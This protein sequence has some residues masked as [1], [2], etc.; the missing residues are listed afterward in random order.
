M[1]QKI[2]RIV[3]AFIAYFSDY[4]SLLGRPLFYQIQYQKFR[5]EI[6]L[7][8]KK[9]KL[10]LLGNGPSFSLIEKHINEFN[11]FDFCAVNLSVNTDLFFTLKPKMLVM[12]DMIFWKQPE[13]DKIKCFWEN[14]QRINW[15]IQIFFPY[16]FPS[17]TK[18]M[19]EKNQYITVCRYAN[20]SWEPETKTAKALKMWLYKK[21]L[22]S[23]NCSNVSIAAI[24][25]AILNG[26]KEINLLGVEHSWMRDIRVNK[27]NEVILIDRHYYGNSEQVWR[28]YEGNPIKLIDFVGSQ[29][30]TFTSHMYLRDFAEYMNVSVI[31]RTEDSY[32]D[33]YD[34]RSFKELLSSSN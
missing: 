4:L 32:I 22:V 6:K 16:D 1:L 2:R 14:I 10:C 26:Y 34:K 25:N 30:V 17:E 21:G 20:N 27:K 13:L 8:D 15:D 33:S 31:N 12:V 7:H 3:H 23:P 9:N 11:E 18:K 5:N 24:Y 29:L 28:D 19:L